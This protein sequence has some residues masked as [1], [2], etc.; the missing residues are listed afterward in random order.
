VSMFNPKKRL[1]EYFPTAFIFFA[2]MT[3]PLFLGACSS[4]QGRFEALRDSVHLRQDSIEAMGFRVLVLEQPG[5]FTQGE[6]VR[7]YIEGDGRPWIAG[8]EVVAADP[9]SRNPLALELMTQDDRGVLY[10]GR[11]C[12]F[13]GSSEPPCTPQLWTSHRYSDKVVQIMT[14]ALVDWLVRH[15]S[16]A[17]ISLVG[18]SGGGVLALLIAERV[19]QVSQVVAIAA[20]LDHQRW[21]ELHGYSPLSGSLNIASLNSW[22]S[23]V[24]RLAVFGEDDRNVPYMDMRHGLPPNTE[25][26]ILPGVSHRCCGN[27]GWLSIL[28]HLEK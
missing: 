8:G 25:V 7:I 4:S 27:L 14:S 28:Q 1:L 3:I 26:L 5:L 20:P 6:N 18:Y 21:A 16:V 2:L 17:D 12:Y 19:T 23:D 10:L 22:R 15:P 24:K 13:I 9:T 11:P